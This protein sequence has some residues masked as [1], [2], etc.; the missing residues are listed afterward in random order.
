MEVRKNEVGFGETV[1][2]YQEGD[3]EGVNE[4]T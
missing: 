2:F 3:D 4:R 1:E